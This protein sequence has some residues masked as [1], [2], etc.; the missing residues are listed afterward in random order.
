MINIERLT[1][2]YD[3]LKA[4]NDLSMHVGAGSVHGLLGAN[5]SGKTTTL[6]C[7]VGLLKPDSG[8]IAVNGIDISADPVQVKRQFGYLPENQ[9]LYPELTAEEY[10]RFIGRLR[11]IAD[12]EV[13]AHADRFFKVFNLEEVRNAMIGSYSMGMKKKTALAGSL[14]GEPPLLIL[15]EPT[16]GLDPPTVYLFKE[17]IRE[18]EKRGTT[19]LIASHNLPFLENLAGG[20]TLIDQGR[21]VAAGS[22]QDLKTRHNM[23]EATLEDIFIHLSG[24]KISGVEE[25]F[26][27]PK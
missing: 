22:L 7:I 8:S 25:L 13:C 11:G 26:D 9:F 14:I 19:V 27:S 3:K 21:V 5:G 17:I 4:V 24:R 6:K 18:L 20:F 16:N 23:P 10:L 15:D 2:C 12:A 1:K